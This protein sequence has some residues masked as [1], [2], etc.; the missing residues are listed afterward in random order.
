MISGNYNRS[1]SRIFSNPTFKNILHKKEDCDLLIDKLRKFDISLSL[2]DN[3][4]VK[5]AIR[6]LYLYLSRNYRNEYIYK[7]TIL[8]K[9]LLGKHNLN[10]ATLLSEYRVGS[11]IA[12]LVLLNGTSTVFEIKTELDSPD[13]LQKQIEDYQK[14]FA[15]VFIVTHHTLSERY[16]K[17]LNNDSIGLLSLNNKF[18]L[19]TNREAYEDFSL[20]NI[21]TMMKCLRKDEY[22]SII[23]SYYKEIPQV[24]NIRFFTEC[25]NL[26]KAIPIKVFHKLMVSQL[27]KRVPIEKDSLNSEQLPQE[28]RHICLCINPTKQQYKLLFNLLNQ[29]L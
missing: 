9:I 26:A 17:N 11:S 6:T 20:L 13:K 29:S 2:D 21:E 4:T 10:T 19:S 16:L 15:K 14:V 27:K 8:N 24:P 3:P 18:Q 12:D 5:D 25:V 1:L 23:A 22:A 7:N 28:L